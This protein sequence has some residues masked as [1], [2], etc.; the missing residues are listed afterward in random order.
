MVATIRYG[1]P[2]TSLDACTAEYLSESKDHPADVWMVLPVNRLAETVKKDIISQKIPIIPSR[3]TTIPAFAEIIATVAYPDV[4]VLSSVEQKLVFSR[5]IENNHEICDIFHPKTDS[6]DCPKKIVSFS[7][8][9]NIVTLYNTLKVRH[10]VLPTKNDKLAIFAS[11]FAAYEKFCD[12]ERIAD[13]P[14]VLRLAS[15]AV[16]SGKFPLRSVYI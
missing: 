6:T 11:I 9:E 4:R 2:G 7:L 13:T 15:V 1:L 10:A 3:I 8:V 14:S 16:R 12:T 5:I